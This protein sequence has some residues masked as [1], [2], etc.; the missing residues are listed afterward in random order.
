VGAVVENVSYYLGNSCHNLGGSVRAGCNNNRCPGLLALVTADV[1]EDDD[2][3]P[4]RIE[5]V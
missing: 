3:W 1:E 2:L 4:G 5:E